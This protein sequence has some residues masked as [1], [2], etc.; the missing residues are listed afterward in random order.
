MTRF[1]LWK[2]ECS[3][4]LDDWLVMTNN[5]K[6][7]TGTISRDAVHQFFAFVEITRLPGGQLFCREA[8]TK[9][10]GCGMIQAKEQE[11]I[12]DEDRSHD[13]PPPQRARV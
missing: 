13:P 3:F 5:Y 9:A 1:C 4:L 11:D 6:D 8:V 7:G 12:D 2:V 10:Q